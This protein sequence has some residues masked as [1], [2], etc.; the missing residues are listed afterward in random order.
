MAP[1]GV[2]GGVDAWRDLLKLLPVAEDE[3]PLDG[4]EDEE[5]RSQLDELETRH[6]RHSQ[7]EPEYSADV[8]EIR[9]QLKK[10]VEDKTNGPTVRLLGKYRQRLMLIWSKTMAEY[11]H[12]LCEVRKRCDHTP[13]YKYAFNESQ[14]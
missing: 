13:V 3:G 10:T 5:V 8:R 4:V 9:L 14:H 7:V 2:G 12:Y 6:E 11:R 1:T